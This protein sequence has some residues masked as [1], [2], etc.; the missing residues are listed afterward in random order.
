VDVPCPTFD[1]QLVLEVDDTPAEAFEGGNV[2]GDIVA[3]GHL[4]VSD[5]GATRSQKLGGANIVAFVRE[6]APWVIH[7]QEIQLGNMAL[8]TTRMRV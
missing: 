4:E 8:V 2:P 7:Y 3:F 1:T 5:E 6:E